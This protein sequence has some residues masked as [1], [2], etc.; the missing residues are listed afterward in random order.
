MDIVLEVMRV[1]GAQVDPTALWRRGDVVGV[2]EVGRLWHKQHWLSGTPRPVTI[3]RVPG[4]ATVHDVGHPHAE[5]GLVIIEGANEARYNGPHRISNV[6]ADSYDY[7]LELGTPAATGTITAD[8]SGDPAATDFDSLECFIPLKFF[9]V[10]TGYPD[11]A[12]NR[13]REV[14]VESH[15]DREPVAAV[16][17]AEALRP[18]F[19]TARQAFW[20]AKAALDADPENPVLIAAV[21]TARA[22]KIAA[23]AAMEAELPLNSGRR[24]WT[25]DVDAFPS[26]IRALINNPPHA[27][28]RSWTQ[29]RNNVTGRHGY[30]HTLPRHR[31]LWRGWDDRRAQRGNR[32][33][34]FN[35]F[36][37]IFDH[38]IERQRL[39]H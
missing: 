39:R 17:A 19:N 33:L 16:A 15:Y 25:F 2:R 30:R 31:K 20:D 38:A 13:I 7:P 1:N 9:V 8:A 21:A 10:V 32:G 26:P 27:I 36:G 4:T 35:V 28:V 12:L 29:V 3:T 34:C 22:E 11:R 18:A 14:W 5:G 23:Q 37:R 24:E 6:Q